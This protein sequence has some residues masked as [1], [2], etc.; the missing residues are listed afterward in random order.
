MVVPALNSANTV[1]HTLSSIFSNKFPS[2]N[3]EV[4]V[5]DNGSVDNTVN[6]IKSFPVGLYFCSKKGYVPAL[7]LG[8]KNARGDIICITASDCIVPND[9]LRKISNFFDNYPDVEGI[10]GPVLSPLNGYKNNIQKF[11][12]ELWVEDQK[13]PTKVIEAQYMR[14]YSGGLLG[15]ANCAYRRETLVSHGCFDESVAHA[16][17]DFCWKLVKKGVRLIFNPDIEVIHIG[18][19]WTLQGVLKQQ[20]KWGKEGTRVIKKHRS[21]NIVDDLKAEIPSFLQL[22]KAFLLLLSPSRQ[23]VTKR[24]LRCCHYM[25]FHLGRIYGRG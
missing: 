21:F 18:F 22:L 5:V 3:F 16:E 15:A 17:V 9:W 6:V 25:A 10:G 4:I 1:Q 23:P 11:T 14:M 7:N 24:L 19:P 8:I 2:G 12:A 20:F 13:F